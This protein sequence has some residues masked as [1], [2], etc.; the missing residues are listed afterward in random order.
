MSSSLPPLS[1]R[2]LLALAVVLI[3][4]IGAP[5]ALAV[6]ILD[7]QVRSMQGAQMDPNYVLFNTQSRAGT[8]LNRGTLAEDIRR[9]QRTGR[10]TRVRAE[11]EES[12]QGITLIYMVRPRAN[13]RTL[14]INGNKKVSTTKITSLINLKRGDLVDDTVAA[15][16]V[17]RIEG[18]YR[19]RFF[20]DPLVEYDL[21]INADTGAADLTINIDE[22]DRQRVDDI[23]FTGN[24]FFSPHQIRAVMDQKQDRPWFAKPLE[25]LGRRGQYMPSAVKADLAAIRELYRDEG[26]LD[27]EVGEP[28]LFHDGAALDNLEIRIPITQGPRYKIGQITIDG[29][30]HFPVQQMYQLMSAKPRGE[31]R[32]KDLN[33]SRQTLRDYYGSRGYLGTGVDMKITPR[34]SQPIVDVHYKIFE[35]KSARIRDIIIRGNAVTKDSVIRRELTF[36]PNDTYNEVRV[37]NSERRLRNTRLFNFVRAT[38][39]PTSNPDEYDVIIDVE[40]GRS[41]SFLTGFGFSSI[42]SLVGFVQLSYNNFNLMG[43]PF[44]GGGQKISVRASLGTRRDSVDITHVEPWFLDQKLRLTTRGYRNEV[45]FFSDEYDQQRTGGSM[46]L[47]KSLGELWSGG[48]TYGLEQI[49]VLNVASDASDI[50]KAEEGSNVKS[51]L[52]GRLVRDS[53]DRFWL[54]SKGN[55]TTFSAGVSGGALGFDVDIHEYQVRSQHHIPIYKDHVLSLKGHMRTVDTYGSEDRVRLFDRLF[56]GGPR[57]IRAFDFRDVGPKDELGE[58]IGGRS[59]WQATAEYSIPVAEAVR[60]ATFYDVGMVEQDSFDWDFGN[61]NSGYGVGI[62]LDIPQ[63]PIQLDYAW[64]LETD[65]FNDRS[66]GRF[67]FMFGGTFN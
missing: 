32:L 2:R 48:I 59:D 22:G 4:L 64:P 8:E 12:E 24:T 17:S 42:D 55:R 33:R 18:E 27:A 49:K 41:G 35:T 43:P 52:T 10:F 44:T 3:G 62:R 11:F 13:L 9:L 39:R 20:T 21:D 60:F 53:R 25:L 37:R 19:K 38:R 15:I 61:R 57:T 23:T 63:L 54:P 46:G 47:S 65:D 6:Q 16:G 50:I 40:E 26:F 67:N 56:N 34:G 30:T 66:S 29:V 1:P 5:A 7:I 31:A 45:R 36:F 58:P 14:A 28:Q 51:S